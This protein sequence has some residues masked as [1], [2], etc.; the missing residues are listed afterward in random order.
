M[1]GQREQCRREGWWQGHPA[2]HAAQG[3]HLTL[4]EKVARGIHQDPGRCGWISLVRLARILRGRR[5][6]SMGC[7]G[8]S[9]GALRAAPGD[10]RGGGGVS[11]G[12]CRDGVKLRGD[13]PSQLAYSHGRWRVGWSRPVRC[14]AWC[15]IK[16]A[17]EW[18][19][20]FLQTCPRARRQTTDERPARTTIA[21]SPPS[22][23][24]TGSGSL[25]FAASAEVSSSKGGFGAFQ[26][27]ATH[28]IDYTTC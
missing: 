10:Q 23:A 15:V 17:D 16:G 18:N 26:T 6:E 27:I 8:W 7:N 5:L 28:Q 12:G 4:A 14:G 25:D 3:R 19:P 11:C 24:Y 1:R 9:S 22:Q 20:L 13:H 21:I 2:F